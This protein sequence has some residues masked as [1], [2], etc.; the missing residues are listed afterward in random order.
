M[1]ALS[2]SIGFTGFSGAGYS[3]NYLDLSP[4]YVGIFFSIGN[5][6]ANISGVVAP[7]VAGMVLSGS[8]GGSG[9]ESGHEKHSRDQEWQ[10][11]FYITVAVYAASMAFY[12]VFAKGK[13][14]Q[15]L[16]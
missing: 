11:L 2:A 12:V 15:E 10:H 3:V 6:I 14:L 16:N 9:G 8:S 13:P 7:I 1:A 4:H 5:T